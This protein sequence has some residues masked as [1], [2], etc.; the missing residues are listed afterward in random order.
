M[1]AGELSRRLRQD[2]DHHD[3]AA[4]L[5]RRRAAVGL[6]LAAAATMGVVALYQVGV[7]RHL[8]DPPLPGFDA[9][10]VHGSAEAYPLGVPDALLGLGSYAATAALAAA[11]G[12]DRARRAP[13][14]PIALAAKATADAAVA[15][16]LT[17]DEAFKLRAFSLWSLFATAATF[18]I[19]PLVFPE[20]RRA[21][22]Q[23]WPAR[24]E[25]HRAAAR[26]RPLPSP[27]IHPGASVS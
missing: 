17:C 8:P 15:T 10:R 7:L 16:K 11:G 2:D 4:D 6:S 1:T 27:R 20:A 12:P 26:Q 19:L 5:R 9:D 22:Q 3:D 21:I 24:H 23:L 18:G 14:L 25:D 13:W